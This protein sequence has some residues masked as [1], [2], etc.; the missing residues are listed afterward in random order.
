MSRVKP[1]PVSGFPEWLPAERRLEQRILDTIR[2]EYELFGFTPI[3]TPSVERM[4]IL[5]AKGGLG[6]QI[7]TLGRPEEGGGAEGVKLGLHFDLTVPLARYVAQ[8]QGKLNFPFRRY[9]IQKV[10]RGERAQRGRFREFYQCDVDIIG[11]GKLDPLYDAELP[12]VLNATFEACGFPDFRIH[13]SNRKILDALLRTRPGGEDKAAGALRAIDKYARDGAAKTRGYLAEEGVDAELIP[14]ILEFIQVETLDEAR[15][16]LE[17]A[18]ADTAGL[19]ELRALI[20]G[21]ID[22]GMPAERI[23]PDFA[24]ARGL[25]YYTGTVFETFIAGKEDWGSVCS[26]GRYDDLAN[27]FTSQLLPGVGFSIG[28]SRLLD[29]LIGEGMLE[30][31]ADSPTRVLV[32]TMD[33]EAYLPRY[34]AIA[35]RLREAGI[36]T[37]V[38]LDTAKI[39]R[40]FAYA[41]DRGIGLAV[42]AAAAEFDAG[43]VAVK[44]LAAR[45]QETVAEDSLIEYIQSK[46]PG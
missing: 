34:L 14:V 32:T 37:E 1:L 20:S 22:L 43:T 19:D 28:L 16:I 15:A 10:W 13:V 30:V 39:G 27:Q 25:D 8:H 12:A 18:G 31:G 41:S 45:T 33:R 35:R 6:R 5:M 9:Q 23:R 36:E 2:H 40:Q 7:Y 29:L 17:R 3:E 21:A 4:E 24:I 46:L 44:D 11:R 38:Y 42:V 26:G